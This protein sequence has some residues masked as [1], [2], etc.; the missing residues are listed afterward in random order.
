M[1]RDSF[2]IRGIY[3][4]A[5]GLVGNGF[6]LHVVPRLKWK[7]TFF[8]SNARYM[9]LIATQ[10]IVIVGERGKAVKDRHV[11]TYIKGRSINP[12]A[13]AFPN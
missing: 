10:L 12:E 4:W 2:L 7:E 5:E 1:T 8:A 6:D 9:K 13:I 11:R 3:C